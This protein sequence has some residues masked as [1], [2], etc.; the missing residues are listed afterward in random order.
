MQL[1]LKF[2]VFPGFEL[3]STSVV[4]LPDFKLF[5]SSVGRTQKLLEKGGVGKIQPY[6]PI[7]RGFERTDRAFWGSH[8]SK[9]R[10]GSFA[11]NSLARRKRQGPD[12]KPS[13]GT[14]PSAALGCRSNLG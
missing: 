9:Q 7:Q 3:M 12:P 2:R 4:H 11:G 10:P 14:L 6:D 5:F 13:P 8:R 1:G